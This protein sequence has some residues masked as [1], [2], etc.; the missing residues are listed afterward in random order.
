M[1]KLIVLCLMIWSSVSFGASQINVGVNGMVCGFCAQG[2]SKK[3]SSNPAV[4]TV[5]VSLENKLVSLKIK[6][7]KELSDETITSVLKDAGYSVSKID[8]K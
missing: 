3:F 4:E 6:D 8:R 5:K 7:G 2:I 1:K